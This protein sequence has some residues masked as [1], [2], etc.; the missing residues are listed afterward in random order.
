MSS[1]QREHVGLMWHG[2]GDPVE[3]AVGAESVLVLYG[4]SCKSSERESGMP[5]RI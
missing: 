5:C 2:E 3:R 1:A 4:E